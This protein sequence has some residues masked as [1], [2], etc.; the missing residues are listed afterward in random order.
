MIKQH[1]E[2]I[3]QAVV[4]NILQN[5]DI[6][7][8]IKRFDQATGNSDYVD[9][10][11]AYVVCAQAVKQ[12]VHTKV[13]A[14]QDNL[15]V[16]V[17]DYDDFQKYGHVGSDGEFNIVSPKKK[18]TTLAPEDPLE[19]YHTWLG[20]VENF[21]KVFPQHSSAQTLLYSSSKGSNT[22]NAEYDIF[23][24]FSEM[25]ERGNAAHEILTKHINDVATQEQQRQFAEKKAEKQE[26]QNELA[27]YQA[28]VDDDT[29]TKTQK[30]N[31]LK[32]YLK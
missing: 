32:I 20:E 8:L 19:E 6:Q 24:L 5:N 2:H 25:R 9:V 16:Y 18:V 29:T 26:R 31:Y 12:V 21:Y 22:K 23:P 1:K 30:K 14:L 4:Q 17:T 28:M 10:Q 11:R 27:K 15:S 7:E 3:K 13:D